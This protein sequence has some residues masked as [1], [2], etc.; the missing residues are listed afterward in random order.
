M[1]KRL[2]ALAPLAALAAVLGADAAAAASADGTRRPRV[3]APEPAYRPGVAQ[4]ALTISMPR[5]R[6]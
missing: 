2:A 4:P 5:I 6:W 3:S 1:K